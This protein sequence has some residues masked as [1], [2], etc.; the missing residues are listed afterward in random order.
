MTCEESRKALI[1]A[2]LGACSPELEAHLSGCGPCRTALAA[3]RELLGRIATEL[4]EALDVRPSPA[5]RPGI[6]Q[7]VA[8][9]QGRPDAGRRWWLVPALATLTG[10]L[11]VGHLVRH[12]TPT[13]TPPVPAQTSPADP[14][15][16]RATES[17]EPTT[18]RVPEAAPT[19]IPREV[20]A[21]APGQH[22]ARD[23]R[24]ETAE[25]ASMPRV[26]V[27]PEDAEAVRRLARRLRGHAARAAVMG[28][29]VEVPFDFTLKPIEGRQEVVTVDHRVPLGTEPGFEEPPS[30]DRTVEK[31]GRDT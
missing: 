19:P 21:P 23:T 7:R 14:R 9:L 25:G 17:V 20:T 5:F 28:P 4:Q 11:V 3:E 10:V 8:A 1:D 30:F 16:V 2:A 18:T 12:T 31:A 27:P 26:F 6:R 24:Q 15:S 29:D 22:T 13:P